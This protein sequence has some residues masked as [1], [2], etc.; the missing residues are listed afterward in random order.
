MTISMKRIPVTQYFPHPL[1]NTIFVL[2]TLFAGNYSAADDRPNIILLLA[3]DLGWTGLSSFG[4]DLYETPNMDA[5]T[6]QGVK[7]TNAYAACTVC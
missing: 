5:L 2:L 6:A 1:Y 3:D 7:F 4:S